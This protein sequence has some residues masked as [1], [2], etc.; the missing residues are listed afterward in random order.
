MQNKRKNCTQ[1]GTGTRKL[2]QAKKPRLVTAR[3]LSLEGI[4]GFY[5]AGDLTN[6]DQEIPD[7]LV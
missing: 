6:A 3:F 1:K 2:Y 5:Q 4:A 7:W